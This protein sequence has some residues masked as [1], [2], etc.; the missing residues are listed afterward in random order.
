[1]KSGSGGGGSGV[2]LRV[3][4]FA[5]NFIFFCQESWSPRPDCRAG[6]LPCILGLSLL[7]ALEMRRMLRFN[8]L[9]M[10]SFGCW[11]LPLRKDTGS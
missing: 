6:Y 10:A 11:N 4:V 9:F 2:S 8:V 1:M 5:I 7:L 3:D